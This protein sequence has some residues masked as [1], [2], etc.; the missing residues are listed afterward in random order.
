LFERLNTADIVSE[1][2]RKTRKK[3]KNEV[4]RECVNESGKIFFKVNVFTVQRKL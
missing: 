3:K 1:Q 4:Q 2:N